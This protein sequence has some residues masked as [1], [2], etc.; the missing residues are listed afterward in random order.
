MTKIKRDEVPRTI[1][2]VSLNAEQKKEIEE[3]ARKEGMTTSAY[4]RMAAIA[5]A[6]KEAM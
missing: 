1:M 6:R 4:V 5:K 2:A 3:A